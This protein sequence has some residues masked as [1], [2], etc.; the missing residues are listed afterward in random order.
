MT[1][2]IP[3]ENRSL[4][5]RWD[6]S[7]EIAGKVDIPFNSKNVVTE[8]GLIVAICLGKK[9]KNFRLKILDPNGKQLV[10]STEHKFTCIAAKGNVVYLPY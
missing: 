3:Q 8:N 10:R 5:A 2:I 1:F 9:P 4:I 7:F 6:G